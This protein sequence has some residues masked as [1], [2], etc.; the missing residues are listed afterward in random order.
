MEDVED[1]SLTPKIFESKSPEDEHTPDF[2]CDHGS[3]L[4]KRELSPCYEASLE[5]PVG[6][7]TKA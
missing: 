5:S 7:W 2:S 4:K 6:R 3:S 1:D